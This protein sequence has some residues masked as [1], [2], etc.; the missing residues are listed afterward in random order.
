MDF[1]KKAEK[2]DLMVNKRLVSWAISLT[3]FIRQKFGNCTHVHTHTQTNIL[4]KYC[5]ILIDQQLGA[6][7]QKFNLR[8]GRLHSEIWWTSGHGKESFV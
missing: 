5:Y 1:A 4:G 6:L 8:Q 3:C 2:I 7:K